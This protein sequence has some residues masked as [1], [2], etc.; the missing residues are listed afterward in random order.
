MYFRSSSL[1]LFCMP[2]FDFARAPHFDNLELFSS[3]NENDYF[4]FHFHDFY[5]VSLITS[6]TEILKNTEQEFIAPSG[7]ISI[8]QL[9]EVHR[10]FSLI[11]SGYSYK[12]LY[13]NPELLRYFNKD[14]P[15]QALERVIYDPELF[16]NL[17]RL[18]DVENQNTTLWEDGFKALVKYSVRPDQKN[19]WTK[20]F[21]LID[22]IIE[23]YPNKQVDTEW[24]SKKFCMSK[25]HF[26]REFKKAKG[27]TPQTYVMLYRLGKAK[28][29]LLENIP[30][31]DIAYLNGFFDPS[32]FTNSFK[33]YFGV[34]PSSYRGPLL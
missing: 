29:M 22:E 2:S 19:L 6:G 33:K 4:P 11:D 8:T 3:E 1:I 21:S 27:V 18:F 16:Q 9:N 5:C 32:H 14:K 20:S 23:N 28:K 25:F 26:I 34:N 15:V 7:T 30:L 12:T 31:N 24:L 10:N 17:S 13:L